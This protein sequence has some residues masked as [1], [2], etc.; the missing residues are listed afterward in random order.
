MAASERYK[1]HDQVLGTAECGGDVRGPQRSRPGASAR[2]RRRHLHW[3][4]GR[5][6]FGKRAAVAG[7]GRASL[8]AMKP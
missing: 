7:A 6:A 4:E 2:A 1:G 8:V 5:V 3:T